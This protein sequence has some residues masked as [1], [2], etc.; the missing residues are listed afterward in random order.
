[1]WLDLAHGPE[2]T[3]PDLDN[4]PCAWWSDKQLNLPL[5]RGF[6]N[7]CN[8]IPQAE[9]VHLRCGRWELHAA[10][11]TKTSKT[12]SRNKFKM[13]NSLLLKNFFFL[14][15]SL[16]IGWLHSDISPFFF[17]NQDDLVITKCL[18]ELQSS[19][20]WERKKRGRRVKRHCQL[21]QVSPE[22]FLRSRSDFC[23]HLFSYSYPCGRQEHDLKC[24]FVLGFCFLFLGFFSSWT[25]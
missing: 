2:F 3:S 12:W 23:L 22:G 9:R 10:I 8:S 17:H 4:S 15:G 11:R 19:H 24:L 5:S 20:L 1:M 16:V 21:R 13:N 25:H 6:L 18:L 14:V 7:L